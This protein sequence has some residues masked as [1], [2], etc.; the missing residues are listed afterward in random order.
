MA[1]ATVSDRLRRKLKTLLQHGDAAALAKFSQERPSGQ[2]LYAQELSYFLNNQ[3]G[4][5]GVTLDDL[6]DIADFF[7]ITIGELFDVPAR[8]LTGDELRLLFAFRALPPVTREHFLGVIE[9]ASVT[10][11]VVRVTRKM[12]AIVHQVE[13]AITEAEELRQAAPASRPRPAPRSVRQPR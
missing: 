3:H 2:R 5:R 4:R 9:P 12:D 13:A 1:K 7:R 6:D 8:E 10:Q 11:A